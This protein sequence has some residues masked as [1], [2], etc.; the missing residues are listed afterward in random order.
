M[1]LNSQC[2][3]LDRDVD[4]ESVV[5]SQGSGALCQPSNQRVLWETQ[6]KAPCNNEL[7]TRTSIVATVDWGHVQ[8]LSVRLESVGAASQLTMY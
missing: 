7:N 8:A 1:H 3:P 2:G 4:D 5:P 6:P